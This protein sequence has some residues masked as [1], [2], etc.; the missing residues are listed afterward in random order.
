MATNAIRVEGLRELQR[1]FKRADAALQKDLR[2]GLRLAAEPVRSAAESLALENIRRIGVPWSRM[3]IGVTQKTVYVAPRER[4]QKGRDRR[5]KRP[6]LFDLLMGRSL[7][8]ALD[9]N[10]SRVEASMET[11]LDTV[12]AAWEQ[13]P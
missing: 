6:N 4:G 11:V 13:R 3:R 5:L 10:I 12:G 9:Q 7:Q 2:T 8:P 1:A